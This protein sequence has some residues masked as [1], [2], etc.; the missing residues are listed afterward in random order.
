MNSR[1]L[2]CGMSARYAIELWASEMPGRW[3]CVIIVGVSFICYTAAFA[4]GGPLHLY[5]PPAQVR[6]AAVA[7]RDESAVPKL[8]TPRRHFGNGIRG[9]CFIAP[10][11][12][13]KTDKLPSG[14]EWLHEIKRDGF[15]I[16]ARKKGS[17]VALQPAASFF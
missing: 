16:I 2:M 5:P 12:P 4:R 7:C 3:F 10:C 1:R 9:S 14:S 17:G 11:L 6:D 15:R 13:T 8:K